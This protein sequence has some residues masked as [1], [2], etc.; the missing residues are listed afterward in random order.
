MKMLTPKQTIQFFYKSAVAW[1]GIYKKLR[2]MNLTSKI[3][4]FK[5]ELKKLLFIN[6]NDGEEIVWQKANFTL[7]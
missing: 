6:Q 2:H 1:N 3:S 4:H 5:L 7:V